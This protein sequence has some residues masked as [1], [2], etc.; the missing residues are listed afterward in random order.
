M[1]LPRTTPHR[2]KTRSKKTL[3]QSSPPDWLNGGV[4]RLD[5]VLQ[6]AGA[7]LDMIEIRLTPLLTS[8]RE[9]RSNQETLTAVCAD[10]W[11]IVD[12][13]LIAGQ[14]IADPHLMP[15]ARVANV[16]RTAPPQTVSQTAPHTSSSAAWS[17]QPT[18]SSRPI[19]P[20]VPP[21]PL[22]PVHPQ[23]ELSLALPEITEGAPFS[24]ASPAPAAPLPPNASP[25]ENATLPTI[26]GAANRK[27]THSPRLQALRMRRLL[28]QP[29]RILVTLRLLQSPESPPQSQ[30]N[31]NLR[32]MKT[33]RQR[34]SL[35]LAEA[36]ISAK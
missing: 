24:S 14:L 2:A 12:T 9:V 18:P 13:A 26:G 32:R 11:T 23:P 30:A 31:V 21:S 5:G 7:R 22:Q 8:E 25:S 4:R 19:A 27:A 33:N 20:S 3:A 10:L 35:T 15:E 1:G 36:T 16:Q 29:Y 17:P 28:Y 6:A 34:C